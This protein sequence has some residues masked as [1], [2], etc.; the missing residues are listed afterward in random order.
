MTRTEK[1]KSRSSRSYF[2]FDMCIRLERWKSMKN[3]RCVFQYL[4]P[5]RQVVATSKCSPA[6]PDF[7]HSTFK[8]RRSKFDVYSIDSV[9]RSCRPSRSLT[10]AR[11]RPSGNQSQ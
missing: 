4:P 2:E 3:L 7:L 8:V 5:K 11:R 9:Y 1:F 6:K 10:I